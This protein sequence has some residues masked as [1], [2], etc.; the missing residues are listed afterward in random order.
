MDSSTRVNLLSGRLVLIAP[1]SSPID[2]VVISKGFDLASIAGDG[3]IAIANEDDVPAGIYAKA[4]L[5]SLGAWTAAEP[6]LMK[7]E[8][9]RTTLALVARGYAPAGIVYE[10][11]AKVDPRVKI[12]GTFPE[13]SATQ[14]TYT[15]AATIGSDPDTLRYLH[16]LEGLEA[17]AILEK[18][19][20][21]LLE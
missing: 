1:A 3:R 17:R 4:V 10:T 16:F 5:T 9:V 15:A 14:V 18:Y 21:Q 8:N 7:A 2:R 6:K 19:G 13:S 20:F 11:D 12:I